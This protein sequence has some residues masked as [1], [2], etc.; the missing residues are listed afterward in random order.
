MKEEKHFGKT[1]RKILSLIEEKKGLVFLVIDPPNQSPEIAG[2][3]SRIGAD[4]GIAA[5]AVGGSVGAQGEILDKTIISI[6]EDSGL[7]VILFPGNIATISKHADAIYFM[8]MLNSLDPYY[9]SGAQTASSLPLKK[10]GVEPIP[11]SYI[12][13]EPG[14]AVGWVG[15]AKLVPRNMPY[16]AGIT[17][18]AGQYMGAHAI[19]LESGGG[20]PAPAPKEMVKYT[21]ELIDVPLIVAGGVRTPKFAYDTIKA[22]ASIVHVGAALERTKGDGAKAKKIFTSI[23]QAA[24]KGGRERK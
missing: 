14:R 10:I 20:A 16:L 8:S 17:A 7:P 21:A 1:Y 9:I 12:I 11:T 22:G 2:K 5:V 19:I 3:L 4:C 23:A 24:L 15:R 6:K 18:L 13:V